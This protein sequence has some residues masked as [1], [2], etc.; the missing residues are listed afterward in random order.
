MTVAQMIAALQTQDPTRLVYVQGR[1][2]QRLLARTVEGTPELHILEIM[3]EKQDTFPEPRIAAEA[4]LA[5]LP[6]VFA[7][8]D[9]E[10]PPEAPQAQLGDLGPP[11]AYGKMP[12]SNETLPV[13]EPVKRKPG[14]PRKNPA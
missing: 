3:G 8:V 5:S 14:R 7:S 6:A 2:G 1:A 12:G 9:P 13:V 10:Q 11:P 4:L